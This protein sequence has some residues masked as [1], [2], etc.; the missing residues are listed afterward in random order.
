MG[1]LKTRACSWALHQ[2]SLVPPRDVVTQTGKRESGPHHQRV[3]LL[4]GCCTCAHNHVVR[5][6]PLSHGVADRAPRST[7]PPFPALCKRMAEIFWPTLLCI[8][9]YCLLWFDLP[10]DNHFSIL[11]SSEPSTEKTHHVLRFALL[12]RYIAPSMAGEW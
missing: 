5:P 7:T 8:S 2:A 6:A 3:T 4:P 1:D 12:S 11:L 9:M 10:R